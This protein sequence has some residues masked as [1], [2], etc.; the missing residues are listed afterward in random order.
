VTCNPSPIARHPLPIIRN[1]PVI[2]IPSRQAYNRVSQTGGKLKLKIRR[3]E[4]KRARRRA[5]D[6]YKERMAAEKKKVK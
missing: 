1:P 3:K 2:D 5:V 6:R 4:L